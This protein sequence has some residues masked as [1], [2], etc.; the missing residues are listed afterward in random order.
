MK[1]LVLSLLTAGLALGNLFMP[2]MALAADPPP[3]KPLVLETSPLPIN[4]KA[5]PGKSVSTEL[6]VRQSSGGTEKLKLTLM[7]FSAYGEEGKPM[8]K[9]REPGD[10][11]FDWAKFDRTSFN[12][13]SGEWQTIKM[14]INVPK[15]AAFGYYYAVVFSRVGDDVKRPQ[16]TSIAGGTATLVLLEANNPNAKRTLELDSLTSKQ[17]VY[18]FLPAHFD[19]KL[20]NTGNVHGV[21]KGGVFISRGNGRTIVSLPLNL[22]NGNILPG[23]KRVYPVEWME[24]WPTY[25]NVEENGK[26]K[27]DKK[28]EPVRRLDWDLTKIMN[29]R[30]G[31]YTAHLVAVYD[32][33]KH[34]VPIEA[35][36]SFWVIPWRF[37]LVL[38]AVLAL[39]GFG[40]YMT[41]RGTLRGAGRGLKRM[42]R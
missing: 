34:D 10:D 26:V 37:L 29:F 39:I 32:D 27:L 16:Q 1:R 18:E 3:S 30:M 14:T 28:G 4:I 8:I 31:K 5:D 35:E 13:P 7:K 41:I 24:G 38:L 36:L 19:V 23:T 21:P 40:V 2:A 9:D 20:A 15:T 6:R 11:Y 17:R 22:G 25:K 33:G 12:A 42:R